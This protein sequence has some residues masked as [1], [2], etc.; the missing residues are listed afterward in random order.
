MEWERGST[1]WKQIEEIV[2][3]EVANGLYK[4]GEKLP[5][6]FAMAERFGVNR[7]TIRNAISSLVEADVLYVEQGRGTFVR[8]TTL[9]YTLGK[10]TRFSQNI[11]QKD[12][13]PDKKLLHWEIIKAKKGIAKKLGVKKGDA[14]I[15]LESVSIADNVPLAYSKNYLPSLRF[16]GIQDT[17]NKTKSLTDAYRY[18]DIDDYTRYSTKILAEMP[19]TFCADILK[20]PKTKPVLRTDGIDVDMNGTPISVNKTYFASQRVQLI[21]NAH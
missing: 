4:P 1:K 20:Q 8:D 3:S 14:I 19:S 21:I 11:S 7:H 5:T 9:D 18:F 2:L 10:R 13:L 16:R 17:F 6:E 15:L 12:K